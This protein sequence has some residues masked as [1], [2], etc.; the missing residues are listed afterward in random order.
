[1]GVGR[2]V[3][4]ASKAAMWWLGDWLAYGVSTYGKT[5][6]GDR[7]PRELYERISEETG[8]A[9]DTLDKA[10]RVCERIPRSQRRDN[11]SFSHAIEIVGRV[12]DPDDIEGWVDFV[13]SASISAKDLRR[14]LRG[15]GA[16]AHPETGDTGV[17][18]ILE[19]AR[20]FSRDYL[21]AQE[22]I[23]P[24]MRNELRKI[25]APTLRDLAP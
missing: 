13:S 9:V 16:E 14:K 1:M 25:L 11:V 24:V 6:W 23:T 3:S 2:R 20:Q 8:Y 15:A 22:R 4:E 18:T 19:A 17:T 5:H 21:A 7:T 12:D 10:R